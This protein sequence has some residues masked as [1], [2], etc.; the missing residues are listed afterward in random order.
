[1]I[2][3]PANL[4]TARLPAMMQKVGKRLVL[5]GILQSQAEAV[6]AEYVKRGLT[7]LPPA[8]QGEWVR[9]DFERR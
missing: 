2:S 4:A 8:V 3:R 9:L 6:T 7:A 5:A 1:M